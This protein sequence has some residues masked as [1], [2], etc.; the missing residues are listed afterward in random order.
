VAS[1]SSC[2]LLAAAKLPDMPLVFQCPAHGQVMRDTWAGDSFYNRPA[3][4]L[5]LPGMDWGGD[6]PPLTG[7]QREQTYHYPN[8][9]LPDSQ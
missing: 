9:P 2:Q 3:M 6:L 5:E 4:P 1:S 8:Q 7:N